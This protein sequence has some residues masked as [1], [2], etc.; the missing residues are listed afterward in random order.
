MPGSVLGG[1]SR[2]AGE[3]RRGGLWALSPKCWGYESF[4]GAFADELIELIPWASLIVPFLLG[5]P[6]CL[7]IGGSPEEGQ[8]RAEDLLVFK[9]KKGKSVLSQKRKAS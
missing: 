9:G 8:D 3:V 6:A 2:I 5:T 1:L 4:R 7:A